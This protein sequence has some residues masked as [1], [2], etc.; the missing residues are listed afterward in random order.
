[1]CMMSDGTD[2]V[3]QR[4]KDFGLVAAVTTAG[5]SIERQEREGRQVYFLFED[6]DQLR[7]TIADYWSDQLRVPARSYFDTQRM[8]KSRIYG[9]E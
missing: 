4:I 1:M 8:L 3:A 5:F 2:Q 6:S 7:S 9:D